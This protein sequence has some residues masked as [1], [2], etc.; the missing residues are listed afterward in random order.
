[1]RCWGTVNSALFLTIMNKSPM[2]RKL[3]KKMQIEDD[4][5]VQDVKPSQIG[6]KIAEEISKKVRS[7]LGWVWA[8]S[9]ALCR[10]REWKHVS[11]SEGV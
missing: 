6:K 8:S 7:S 1:M 11:Y 4:D 5:K 9:A 10:S 3:A 2:L